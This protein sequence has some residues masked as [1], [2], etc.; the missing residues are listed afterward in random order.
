MR[1]R[2]ILINFFFLA[3]LLAL[4]Y[5]VLSYGEEIDSI[6]QKEYLLPDRVTEYREPG[7]RVLTMEA[8]AYILEDG[9]GDGLTS[10]LRRPVVGR[11]VAVDPN[12]IP[13]N[14]KLTI[15]G[16]DGYIAEDTGGAIKGNRIDIYF[17]EGQEAHRKAMEFGRQ[18]VRV[19]IIGGDNP[20]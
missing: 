13:Y 18:T 5:M 9:N 14:T 15:N 11:T 3:L 10:T 16:I 6:G 12:Y 20:E 19:Q 4:L 2:N 8:T 17:G 1:V 7:G